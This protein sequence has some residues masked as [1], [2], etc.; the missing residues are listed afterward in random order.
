M[1]RTHTCGELRKKDVKKEVTL[2]G[3]VLSRRDHGGIIFI[4]LRDRYG[5]TQVVFDPDHNKEV[6]K[7]AEQLRREFVLQVKGKVR[8]RREGMEN[9]KLDTGEIEVITDELNILNR[10]DTPPLEIEDRANVNEDFRLKYRYL[11]LRRPSLQNNL[12]V[13]HKVIKATRDFFDK[14]GFIEIET[15][16]LA[17]STPEGAR[18]YLVPSRTHPGKFYALPQSP[19]IFKQLCMVAGFDRYLQIARCF[20][21]E[22]LRAD[23]QPE[24]TQIDVEMSFI[25]EEDIYNTMERLMKKIFKAGMG[26]DVKIPFQRI[27]Y[28]EAMDKYGTDKPDVRFDLPLI[29]ITEAMKKSDFNVFKQAIESGGVVKC[30]NAKDCAKFSRKD[31]EELEEVTRIY[32][33]KGL[34]WMKMK[35]GKLDSSIVKF[36]NE[37]AQKALIKATGAKN[38]DLLLFGADHKHFIVNDSL[39]NLR[40]ALAKKLELIDEDELSFIW[41]TDFPLLEYDEELQRH[42]SV[43]HPFTSPKEEDIPMLEKDPSKVRSNAY[44]LALNGVE[45]GGGSIRIHNKELQQKMFKALG[46]SDKEA[47]EKFGFLMSAFKYGAPPHGGIAFGVDRIIALMTGNESIREVIAFPKNKAAMSLMDNAPNFVDDKQLKELHVKL[48]FVR[49]SNK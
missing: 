45:I 2:C 43:H 23:R 29:D 21:D 6:H 39:G 33:A 11:D 10:A 5:L 26:K 12:M 20:R 48:D 13:R 15:P 46:I 32:G 38:G 3:W 18:D 19:Q 25:T 49:K 41:V 27:T 40:L 17:K 37:E 1:L 4:D 8:P 36:F 35:D 9:P 14:E 22:D 28:F 30:I 24:F 16:I 7:M 31:I 44:D 47:E 34:A 42:V